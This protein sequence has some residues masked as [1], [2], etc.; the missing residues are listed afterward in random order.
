MADNFTMPKGRM[1]VRKNA[2][3]V[4]GDPMRP[5]DGRVNRR[6]RLWDFEAKQGSAIA[7]L[8]SAYLGA[9]SAVDAVE[10]HKASALKSGKYT[11]QG[12]ADD[13]LQFVLTKAIPTFKRGRDAIAAAKREA[14][15]LRDKI[16]LQPPDKGDVAGALLRREIRD[17]LS[18]MSAKDRDRFINENLERMEPIVAEAILTAPSWLSGV[19]D[20]HRNLLMEKALEAQFGDAVV[21]VQELE[22]AIEVTTSAV[23][24]GRDEVRTEAGILD[25]QQFERLAAPNEKKHGAPWLKRGIENGVEIVRKFSWDAAKNTG[26][27]P[28]AT[29]ADIETGVFYET[30]EAFRKDNPDWNVAA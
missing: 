1:T 3:Q 14:A 9:L 25:P 5:T 20:S 18:G 23:E 2:M 19:S 27:W 11:P 24:T 30:A 12:S 16:K 8:E 26:A 10:E 7:K 28:V 21:E 17:R 4:V 6:I 13:A 15:S 29:P 22:R